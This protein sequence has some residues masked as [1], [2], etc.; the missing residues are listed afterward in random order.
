MLS[1]TYPYTP[2]VW[3]SVG[4]TITLDPELLAKVMEVT[5]TVDGKEVPLLDHL[6]STGEL[7]EVK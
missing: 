3:F 2:T 7:V 1:E 5:K 4:K 6:L